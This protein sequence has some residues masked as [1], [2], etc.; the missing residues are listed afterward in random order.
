MNNNSYNGIEVTSVGRVPA[1]TL[2]EAYESKEQAAAGVSG[3][4]KYLSPL[5]GTY[6]FKLFGKPE[7]AGDFYLPAYDDSAF[8]DITV[9]G[10]WELSG[11]GLPLYTNTDFPFG[12][13]TGNSLIE[14]SSDGTVMPNPPFVPR[15][16]PSGCYRKIFTLPDCFAGRRV[17]LR[18]D[19]VETAYHVWVNGKPAGYGQDSKLPGEFDITDMLQAGENLLALLVTRFAASTYLEDQDYW[20]LSGIHRD[21]W[22]S[23]KP[24][25]CIFDYKAFAI[26]D[27]AAGTGEVTI[28]ATVARVKGYAGCSVKAELY[29]ASGARVAEGTG[30]VSKNAEY[31]NDNAP[32]MNA[33]KIRLKVDAPALW[34]PDRPS[35]YTLALTLLSPDGEELDHE[36]CRIG[37]KS[38]EV[39][40]GV[41]HING[42]R[43]IVNG[44]NRH[45]HAWR[46]GRTV[47]RA[48]MLEEIKL[49]KRLGV[50]AVRTSHYP[51]SPLWYRLCDE[52]GLLIVCECNLETHGLG[53]ALTHDP[54]WALNFLERAVRMVQFFKNHA[55]IF[56][57]SLGNESGTGPNHAAMYGW[58]KEFDKTRLCQFESGVPGP[59]ISDVRGCMYAIVPHIMEEMLCNE[60][61]LRPV[62]LVEYLYQM[63]NAGG[64]MEYFIELTS[65]YKRFQGGFTW[66]WQ[67]K[68]LV[69][70]TRD[71]REYFGYAG[72][73][74]EPCYDR[75]AP[76][77]MTNNG[78][79]LPDLTPKPVAWEVKQ[80]YCPLLICQEGVGR[81]PWRPW[82]GEDYSLSVRTF[83]RS[84]K[85]FSVTAVLRE[86]GLPISEEAVPLPDA[87]PGE[88]VRFSYKPRFTPDDSKEYHIDFAV[89]LSNDTFYASAGYELGRFQF[90][91]DTEMK[92]APLPCQSGEA[93]LQTSGGEYEVKASGVTARFSRETGELL[94]LEKDGR[95]KY[96]IGGARPAFDRPLSGLVD[97]D[98]GWGWGQAYQAMNGLT[99]E[100]TASR[101]LTGGG[102]VRLEFDYIIRPSR[103]I[104]GTV[105]Y[106]IR[107][108]GCITVSMRADAD[109][110]IAALPR[111]GVRLVLPPEFER[112]AYYGYGPNENYSDR[113]LS[114]YAA[115]HDSDVSSQHFPFSPPSE[116]GGHEE[117]R[118]V[119]FYADD[120]RRI[121]F[122]SSSPF[123]FDA[124]HHTVE[125]YQ[126]AKHDHELPKREETYLHIDAAHGPIGS[127][128][129]WSS[130]MDTKYELRGGAFELN[131][132]IVI[133]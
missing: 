95:G 9:P 11:H 114:A 103:R 77:Y 108:D 126:A 34:C 124:K 19:G 117:T 70:H 4:S 119:E 14:A 12:G 66:D 86:D 57:W 84:A 102:S 13:D 10:N 92:K 3:V 67:D 58:I 55:C 40:G 7:D 123:H 71:G 109:A 83:A 82:N 15:D 121:R 88:T 120:G 56:S 100:I 133:E 59:N 68:C 22:L 52:Y 125:D 65:R 110:G 78:L 21:V 96:L 63:R 39:I 87:K 131:F 50:N 113:K 80:A 41:V 99:P 106:C 28:D 81:H 98:K 72:C 75:H 85:D 91:L 111:A 49:M 89:A 20:Y 93:A 51:N 2:W 69:A 32:T 24:E 30:N 37:F 116:T 53:G 132:N 48:H 6:R 94:F 62:I 118:W 64:G 27:L 79:V 35:L 33:A 43:L 5:N 44:V 127:M 74:G 17:Y 42:V 25:L 16:N 73:F 29:D 107:G 112:M 38:V 46:T 104:A 115:V 8:S 60:R 105:C 130:A 31:R 1:H 76:D 36:G 128:M 47:S 122:S 129:A 45:E 90:R 26:P 18:L 61:D 23:A 101:S 97:N 54:A